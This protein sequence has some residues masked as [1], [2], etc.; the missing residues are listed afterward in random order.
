MG[1]III[2]KRILVQSPSEHEIK[3]MELLDCA[4][5]ALISDLLS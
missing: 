3:Q 2:T 5:A 4:I 1:F